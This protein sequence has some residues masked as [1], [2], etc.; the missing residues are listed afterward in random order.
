VPNCTLE[1]NEPPATSLRKA[2]A[3]GV[4][5]L[6]TV[7]VS[8]CGY[9]REATLA[10]CFGISA[11]MDAYFGAMFIPIILYTVLISGALSP[12]FIPILLEQDSKGDRAQLSETF[13]VLINTVVLLL[14]IIIGIGI[15]T[16]HTWLRLL[17]AG[18]SAETIQLATR[19]TYIMLPAMLFLALAGVLTAVLNGFNRFALA[20]FAPCLGSLAIVVATLF[21]RGNGA[22][23][24]VA[25]A[26]AAGFV[27]QFLLLLPT[28]RSLGI[29]YRPSFNLR[30]AANRRLLRLGAPLCGYLMLA[31]ASVLLERNL[32]SS[33]SAG[34][35]A[36]I[37]YAM[38][39]FAVPATFLVAPLAVVVYPQFA[40]QAL[41]GKLDHLKKHVSDMFRVVVFI[42]LP[43]SIWIVLNALPLTR[44]LYEHGQFGLQ[45][46]LITARVF[47]LYSIGILPN[48]IGIIVLRCFY[49]IQDTVTPMLAEAIDLVFYFFIASLLSKHYGLVGLALARG[50]SFILVSGIF[51]TVLHKKHGLMEIDRNFV[52]FALKTTLASSSVMAVSFACAHLLH[53]L[54]DG[55]SIFSRLIG[56]S[57]S[58]FLSTALFL[59]IAWLLRIPET[60]RVV[61]ALFAM[62]RERGAALERLTD[63]EPQFNS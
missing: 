37:S 9:L 51:I 2:R 63:V 4:V 14:T 7:V 5:T 53:Q 57:V 13:S 29:Q 35:V 32:A 20:S 42:F 39:L 56:I 54:V 41:W 16:A 38:R 31:N 22:I 21:S 58:G 36:T 47:T 43:L 46:S 44:I 34:A 62:R 6:L 28:T 24:I 50:M 25:F 61:E 1:V 27:L 15:L 48:A 33:L 30:H 40:R 26:T 11:V 45:D 19:L 23:Y 3:V 55:G 10:A 52:I 60:T 12:V 49:A 8:A 17:F 18:Y 59:A